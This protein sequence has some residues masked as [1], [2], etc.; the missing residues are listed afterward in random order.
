MAGWSYLTG[1]TAAGSGTTTST[2]TAGIDTTGASLIVVAA[3]GYLAT[4][5]ISD[6]GPAQSN[7]GLW[8]TTTGSPAGGSMNYGFFWIL[9]PHT[10][11]SHTFTV[12][13][14]S[15]TAGYVGVAVAAFQDT[16]TGAA[17]DKTAPTSGTPV[18]GTSVTSLD[19]GSTGTLAVT[20]EL[21]VSFVAVGNA[22]PNL[23][24]T[25]SATIVQNQQYSISVTYGAAIAYLI[26]NSTTAIDQVWNWATG[27]GAA[28]G[29]AF[30]VTFNPGTATASCPHTLTTLG[31]GCGIALAGARKLAENPILTRRSLILPGSRA[32]SD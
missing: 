25:N 10:A 5:Q 17:V 18:T 8:T 14:T 28:D 21:V 32:Y 27:G 11:S 12:S 9:N 31:V 6:S 4:L 3:G 30:T 2:T 24:I 1:A 26:Y 16:G 20:N 15:G 23:T 22:D 19:T 7:S 13:I 29:G